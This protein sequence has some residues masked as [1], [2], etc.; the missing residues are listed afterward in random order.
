[1]GSAVVTA[2]ALDPDGRGQFSLS[3]LFS[4]IILVFTEFGLGNAGTYHMASGR[5]SRREI[6]GSHAF[7]IVARCILAGFVSLVILL[8]MHEVLFPNVPVD[9]LVLGILNFFPLAVAG[10]ILPLLI[11]MGMM[12]TYNLILVISSFLALGILLFGWVLVGLDVRTALL[13]QLGSSYITAAIIWYKTR[14]A[15]G[16]LA[17]PNFRYLREAY[18]FGLGLYASGVVA[19]VNTRMVWLLINS[20]VGVAG[21][22]LYS[23]AQA[24]T[25]RIYLI[26]DALGTALFPRIAQDP[27]G[28]S[29]RITPTVF[30]IVLFVGTVLAVILALVADWLVL[31]LFGEGFSGSVPVLRLLLVAVVLSGGWR[32]LSNDLNGQG[33][34]YLSAI[35]NI[36]STIFGLGIAWLI[37]PKIGIN[38]AAWAAVAAAGVSLLGGLFSLGYISGTRTVVTNLFLPNP[39]ERHIISRNIYSIAYA[40]RIGRIS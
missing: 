24:A 33:Y 40:L 5:W 38:G 21:V 39:S 3:L 20:I 11:G 14:E 19:F 37:L 2:R 23:I 28:N 36:T 34:S 13:L 1:M 8:G 30:R 12:R 27:K 10:S 17:R 7:V 22:G 9:C 25:D 35:V 6:L 31:F 29:V 15:I 16:A 26:P 4:N 32:I 18:R